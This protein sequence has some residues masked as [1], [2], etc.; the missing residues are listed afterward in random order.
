MHR[1]GLSE[2]AASLREF[3]LAL[4]LGELSSEGTVPLYLAFFLSGCPGQRLGRTP[5]CGKARLQG[6][7]SMAPGLELLALKATGRMWWH[8]ALWPGVTRRQ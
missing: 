4:A 8:R 1:T 2:G 6:I 5:P 7:P 3:T